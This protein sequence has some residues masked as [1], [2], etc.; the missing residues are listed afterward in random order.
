MTRGGEEST[1][2]GEKLMTKR[3][4]ELTIKGG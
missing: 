4:E 1:T 3:G 2:G